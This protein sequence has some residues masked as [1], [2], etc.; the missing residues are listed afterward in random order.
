MKKKNPRYKEKDNVYC[1]LDANGDVIAEWEFKQDALD[2]KKES[3]KED[4]GRW[5]VYK[6]VHKSMLGR[7]SL[8]KK[9]PK[10]F[11]K[12]PWPMS[13]IIYEDS[14]CRVIRK[15]SKSYLDSPSYWVQE[16]NTP[17]SDIWWD[18]DEEF[19]SKE[20]AMNFIRKKSNPSSEFNQLELKFLDDI[21][22]YQSEG[23]VLITNISPRLFKEKMPTLYKMID[24]A[25][26]KFA[27]AVKLLNK[28]SNPASDE[29]LY[30]Y[31][32]LD[33]RGDFNADIRDEND[34]SIVE[35]D[36]EYAEFLS[37]E[38][39]NLRDIRSVWAYFS[40]LGDIPKRAVLL[41]G[42]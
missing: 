30:Y 12:G 11:K 20:D 6:V 33:E 8:R 24:K 19:D 3:D 17:K 15:E 28:K 10:T 38:G 31:I 42:N 36:T 14:C 22:K 9:N 41:K 40:A 4:R 25:H 1:S 29:K 2:D 16:R 7:D 27:G 39:V 18:I 21:R 13:D 23:K 35:I 34:H 26:L 5:K 37:D 32:N